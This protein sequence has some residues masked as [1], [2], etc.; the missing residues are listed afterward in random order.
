MGEDA[1]PRAKRPWG[2]ELRSRIAAALEKLIA[3]CEDALDPVKDGALPNKLTEAAAMA[4]SPG[5]GSKLEKLLLAGER[6]IELIALRGEVAFA[7]DHQGWAPDER[8]VP[9]EGVE[10]LQPQELPDGLRALGRHAGSPPL[11][12]SRRFEQLLELGI[13]DGIGGANLRPCRLID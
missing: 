2:Y 10:Q 11:V 13:D 4:S 8:R 9:V 12:P 3:E 1:T 6:R 7:V 5:V